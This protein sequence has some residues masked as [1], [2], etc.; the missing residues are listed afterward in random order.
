M[1]DMMGGKLTPAQIGAL[2]IA[3]RM[4]GESVDEITA[5]AC[6]MREHA[7][8][9]EV[10]NTPVVDT[11]G[12][13]GDHSGTFNISTAAAFVAAGAGVHIAKH[14]NRSVSSSCGSADVLRE[15]GV[16]IDVE[17]EKVSESIQSIGIGF[18]FAQ[19]LHPAMKYAATPRKE[20]GVRTLF[21]M[22][23]PL[24][25]P[26]RAK[27][28]VLGVFSPD[29]TD[30]FASVLKGLGS[31]RVLVVH[32]L[33]RLDEISV[34][35]K[36]RVTE[37]K[38]GKIDTY[39]FD[40]LPYISAYHQLDDIKGGDAKINAKIMNDAIS[41]RETGA[42]ADAA[43]LNGAA[44]IYVAGITDTFSDAVEKS[45]ESINSGRALNKLEELIRFTNMN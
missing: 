20:L 40:P 45:K 35:E 26:A 13:G 23:G 38:D 30:K 18:L 7:N 2:L 1:H 31:Q 8:P 11:C 3:L 37:L 27:R 24:T 17:P 39:T 22:L 16:N 43:M 10:G 42:C 21:N 12:T 14:G 34:T 5:A 33:D 36:T 29:L 19:K 32:G 28:Q 9:I 41:G 44:A 6:V 15:L 4:K 25:N